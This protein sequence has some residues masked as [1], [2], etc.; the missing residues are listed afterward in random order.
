[1]SPS[2]G[3]RIKA[4]RLAT[5]LGGY[6]MTP[7]DLARRVQVNPSHVFRVEAGKREHPSVAVVLRFA[8]ALGCTDLETAE[9][10]V[11][12]GHRPW[13]DADEDTTALLTAVGCAILAGDYRPHQQDVRAPIKTG[14]RM[15]VR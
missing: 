1:M 12:A 8:L 10:L 3:E 15:A 14:D 5:T 9:L 7:A 13:P 2:F 4:L 11:S 6:P